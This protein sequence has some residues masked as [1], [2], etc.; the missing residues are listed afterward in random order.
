MT[1]IQTTL[2]NHKVWINPT[3]S[4]EWKKKCMKLKSQQECNE[5]HETE[6][7]ARNKIAGTEYT[8]ENN[9]IIS[10]SC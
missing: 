6:I 4:Q 5:M 8:S 3:Q 9:I 1:Q 7:T 10:V 2:S